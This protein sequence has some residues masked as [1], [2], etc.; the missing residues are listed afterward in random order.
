MTEDSPHRIHH[1]KDHKIHSIVCNE[2]AV[3]PNTRFALRGLAA[4]PEIFIRV[5]GFEPSEAR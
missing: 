2:A 3:R 4:G 5:R 1:L